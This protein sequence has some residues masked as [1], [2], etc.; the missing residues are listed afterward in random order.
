MP[1]K[2]NQGSGWIRPEKRLAIHLR[3]DFLCKYCGTSL[4]NSPPKDVTLDHVV[5]CKHG[6]SNEA[7]NLVTCCLTCNLQ[8][9]D[10]PLSVFAEEFGDP[11]ILH[12]VEL[13]A[14]GYLN[15]A[16][17]KGVLS[18]RYPDPRHEVPEQQEE[19]DC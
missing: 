13:A 8:K 7:S 11:Y 14:S 10:R 17:A 3:D 1:R 6:G 15:V 12:A 5:P 19:P 18:G 4:K 16:L 2:I 9:A